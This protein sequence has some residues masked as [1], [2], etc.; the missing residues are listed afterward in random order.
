MLLV[1]VYPA[2]RSSRWGAANDVNYRPVG[3]SCG[4]S[5]ALYASCV[6]KIPVTVNEIEKERLKNVMSAYGVDGEMID[7]VL[8][9]IVKS[10]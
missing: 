3:V 6:L 7:R 1:Q 9:Y 5:H 2:F 8:V 10:D 4:G